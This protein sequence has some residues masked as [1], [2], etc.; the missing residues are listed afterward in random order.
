MDLGIEGRRAVVSAASS[1][2]GK[3]SALALS[4]EGARVTLLARDEMRLE[5]AAAD[6]ALATGTKPDVASVDLTDGGAVDAFVSRM[7]ERGDPVSILVTNSGG[8]PAK[9]FLECTPEDWETAFRL[10]LL[11]TVRLIR[12]FLPG[13]LDQ[14]WGRIVC[15]TSTAAKEPIDNLLLSNSLRAA[16]SGMA[17]TLSREVGAKGVLV[18]TIAPGFHDTPA[19]DRLVKKMIDQGKAT[20]REEVYAKWLSAV[21]TDRLGD[22]AGFGRA[23]AFLAS[24]ACDYLTGVNVAVDGGRTRGAF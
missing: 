9:L 3:A 22:P 21:P 19:L 1:G 7:N 11:S 17:K 24:D 8:P 15:V 13:M 18:N 20:S 23:V 6:I 2:L 12:G 14:G 10:L 4:Q 5:K 16:V